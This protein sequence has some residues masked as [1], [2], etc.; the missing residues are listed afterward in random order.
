[1]YTYYIHSLYIV[2]ICSW[3]KI[4]QIIFKTIDV[5]KTWKTK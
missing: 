5:E 3:G 2:L 4:I 1:M